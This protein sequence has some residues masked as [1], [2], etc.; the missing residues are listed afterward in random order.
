M[1][2]LWASLQGMNV[3]AKNIWLVEVAKYYG[4]DYEAKHISFRGHIYWAEFEEDDDHVL[5]SFDTESAFGMPATICL[6]R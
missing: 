2:D 5:L 3:N 1:S 4:I 6:R